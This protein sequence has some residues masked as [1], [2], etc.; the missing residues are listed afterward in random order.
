MASNRKHGDVK[1]VTSESAERHES[2]ADERIRKR[3]I[4]GMNIGYRWEYK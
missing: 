1:T 3:G 2:G 4:D